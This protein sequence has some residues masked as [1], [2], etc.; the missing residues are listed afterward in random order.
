MLPIMDEVEL[1][2]KLI[3]TEPETLTTFLSR[4]SLFAPAFMY[5]NLSYMTLTLKLYQTSVAEEIA[6]RTT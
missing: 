5:V 6:I 1:R 2:K 4:F 3:M